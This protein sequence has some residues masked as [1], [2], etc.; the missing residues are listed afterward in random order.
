MACELFEV[1]Q[2][3]GEN[4]GDQVE[5][6]IQVAVHK[7]VSETRNPSETI[8]EIRGQDLR[9]YQTVNGR[10]VCHRVET[11]SRSQM[12]GD[13]EGGLCGE[14]KTVFYGPTV[15][16]IG[17]ELLR[18]TAGVPTQDADRSAQRNETPL[19]ST[20]VRTAR[21]HRR[22]SVAASAACRRARSIL[23]SWGRKSK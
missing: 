6:N 14:L 23:S 22:S 20:A 1:I 19:H 8:P 17:A 12:S 15:V 21:S 3:F 13:I 16:D 4:L 18:R 5:V 9:F 2:S 11:Q 10:T 7:H